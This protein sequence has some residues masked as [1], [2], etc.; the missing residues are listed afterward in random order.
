MLPDGKGVFM[1]ANVTHRLLALGL[2]GIMALGL[3]ACGQASAPAATSGGAEEAAQAGGEE[4]A[5]GEVSEIYWYSTVAGFGPANWKTE[6]SP[7]LDYM[8]DELGITINLEQPPTDAT[9]KLGL[10]VASNDLPDVIS[11]ADSDSM[12]MLIDSG[13]IWD[14]QTFLETYDPESHLLKDFPEDIKASHYNTYGGWYSYPSHMESADNRK[15]FPPDAQVWIDIVE[16]GTN[17]AIMFNTNVM[18]AIGI[19]PEDVSTESGFYEACQKVVDSGYAV[20]GQTV[21][22]VVFH[23]DTWINQSLDAAIASNFGVMPV[24]EEGHY[25]HKELDPAYKAALKFANNLVQKGY[26]DVNTLIIDEAALK[27][28]LEPE[29]VF[30]WIGNQAQINK[31]GTGWTSFGPILADNGAMP[32]EAINMSAGNGWIQT[33]VSKDAK[34]PEKIAKWLSWAS[35]REGLLVNYYG[36]EGENYQID[37]NGIVTYTDEQAQWRAD[38]YNNNILLWAFANTSFER[39]TEPVPDPDSNRGHEAVC[40]TAMGVYE[41]TYIYDQSLLDFARGNVVEPSSDLGIAKS[42]IDSYLES[43]KAKIVSAA[44]DAAFEKEYQAMIDTLISYNVEALDAEYD[45]VLQSNYEAYGKTIEYKNAA[46]Y[47]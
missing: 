8:R 2:A 46:I 23:A 29:A 42:Q 47:N 11:V 40:M 7:A 6:S 10:M 22:P 37:D 28:Y 5:P 38:N 20:D 39:N 19:T 12:K 17:M 14:M 24:D 13:K 3:A 35:S 15:N 31:E 21:L 9:T 34:N 16:K 27:T 30:C 18:D 45:K 1:R 33:V 43:Q 41:G 25:R 26:L 36:I 32:A 4:A 44:D